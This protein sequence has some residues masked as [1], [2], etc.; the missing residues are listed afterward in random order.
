MKNTVVALM[1]VAL[2]TA[3]SKGSGENA[4]SADEASLANGSNALSVGAS[5]SLKLNS[6]QITQIT[7]FVATLMPQI[8]RNNVSQIMGSAS[9]QISISKNLTCPQGGSV[10]IDVQANANKAISATQVNASVS[11]DG[12]SI[13]FTNCTIG[14][15]K[16]LVLNGRIAVQE[17][18]IAIAVAINLTSQSH[19]FS[20]MDS[21]QLTSDLTVTVDQ[22]TLSCPINISQSDSVNGT[23]TT[24]NG[25]ALNGTAV[26]QVQGSICGS[27][28]NKNFNATF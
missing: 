4:T 28:L 12:S 1:T 5:A 15:Q 13:T 14:N 20:A 25:I 11:S 23:L 7:G 16:P 24:S 17:L 27:T 26:S 2:L 6:D 22:K 18:S 10:L 8:A 3:C 9:A 21:G 19:S